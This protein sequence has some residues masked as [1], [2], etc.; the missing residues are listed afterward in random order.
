M[1]KCPE[2]RQLFVD[3]L[4]DELPAAQQPRFDAH[5]KDCAACRGELARLRKTLDV[6][7]AQQRQ[8][9]GAPFWESYWERLSA[10]NDF[11]E[12]A[13]TGA[14]RLSLPA[15]RPLVYRLLAAAAVLIVG[16]LIGKYSFS[17]SANPPNPLSASANDALQLAAARQRAHH[18]LDKSQVLILNLVNIDTEEQSAGELDISL[19]QDISSELVKEAAYLRGALEKS[20]D[21]QLRTLVADLEMI[22]L[23]IANLEGDYDPSAIE[24]VR[25]SVEQGGVLIK[26]NLENMNRSEQATQNKGAAPP[27]S[28]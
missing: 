11:P 1:M 14:Q 26:I 19:Q 25:N 21:H 2:C 18:Y 20:R 23:Q 17:G 9:P 10:R 24:I 16:I 13:T 27:S 8:D 5:L 28:I 22:L 4:Y 12:T 6:M 15:W 7:H 3:V